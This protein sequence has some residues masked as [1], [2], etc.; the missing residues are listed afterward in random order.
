[1]I[2]CLADDQ[3]IMVVTR[4]AWTRLGGLSHGAFYSCIGDKTN[5]M[6]KPSKFYVPLQSAMALFTNGNPYR[7]H[8]Q[9]DM[10]IRESSIKCIDFTN[11]PESVLALRGNNI[12]MNSA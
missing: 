5:E 9:N 10:P 3:K 12:K 7:R 4:L 1:M 8:L 11:N 6:E 2:A